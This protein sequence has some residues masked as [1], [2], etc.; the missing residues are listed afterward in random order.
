M[1]VFGT[2]YGRRLFL[3]N[4]FTAF[5]LISATIQF[6]GQL[7]PSAVSRPA[8]ITVGVLALCVLWA[9]VRVYPRSA[10]RH[11]YRHPPV[12][13]SV[14]VGDL[15]EQDAHIVVGVTDTFDTAV[16]GAGLISGG[17]VQGQLVA[18]RYGG[19]ARLLDRDLTSALRRATP[20]GTESRGSKR[21]GKLN[22]YDIGT[23]AVIGEPHRRV[24]ALAYSRMGNDLVARS[25]VDDLWVSLGKL[26]DA[27]D[28]HAQRGRVAI[29]LIGSGLARIDTLERQSL[30]R[31]ILLSFV[32]RS[33]QGVVCRELT[34]VV[35]PGDLE[36]INMLEV[37]TFLRTL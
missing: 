12:T 16:D 2:S 32:S 19:D 21:R 7:F 25:S 27:V 6:V 30:L 34:V 26:W 14:Q 4:L 3:A 36:K 10:V 17:S 20:V 1:R 8:L 13:V 33:R 35:W 18:R 5:G 31:M 23:V 37:R 22:R 28:L 15:F 11:D 9:L 29:P 24:F